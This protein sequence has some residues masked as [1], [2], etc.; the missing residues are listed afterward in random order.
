MFSRGGNMVPF[1][2]LEATV[3]ARY[4]RRTIKSAVD[5]N[6]VRQPT[7][8]FCLICIHEF[9]LPLTFLSLPFR[10]SA[11]PCCLLLP[12]LLL[13]TTLLHS[14]VLPCRT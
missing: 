10:I 1:E 4:V 2:L 3:D 12:R 13:L 7:E 8:S 11:A 5:G 14:A 6:M 9:L